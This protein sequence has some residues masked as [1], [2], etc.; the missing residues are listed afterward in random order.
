[1]LLKLSGHAFGIYLFHE[2]NLFILKKLLA[3][4][5]PQTP[6]MQLA[7]YFGIPVAIFCYCLTLSVVMKKYLPRLYA[8]LTGNRSR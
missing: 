7:Q 1:M 3:K 4:L 5:L 8:L 6:V 2:M